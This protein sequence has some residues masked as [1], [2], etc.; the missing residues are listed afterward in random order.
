MEAALTRPHNRILPSL[1]IVLVAGGFLMFGWLAYT[2]QSPGKAP[3]YYKLTEEGGI[4]K[5]SKLGLD[6]WP[7]ISIS[8]QEIVVDGVDKPV[9]VAHLAR[10][11]NGKPVMLSWENRT[12]EP[13]VFVDGK[14]SELTALASAIVKHVPKDAAILAWWDTSRQIQL[15]TGYETVFKSHLGEPLITPPLWRTR[16]EAIGEYERKFWGAP[17][18]A[19]ESRKFQRFVDALAADA[20]EGAAILHELAGDRETYVAV[21]LSDLYKLGLMRPDRLGVAYK[22]FPLRGGDVHGLS[23][24]V[25]RWQTDNN[26]TTYTVHG[27]TENYVRAYFLTDAKSGNTL[28]AQMLPMTTSQPIELKAVRLVYQHGGYWVYKLPPVQQSSN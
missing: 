13:M 17:A 15:L 9:A 1:G 19:D 21:H 5:F 28:L 22:D 18:T 6:A 8:K 24:M 16:A 4:E 7:D 14:L 20:N 12:G 11:G 26:Y 2:W 27:L 25:K 10:R 3:Y 23:G